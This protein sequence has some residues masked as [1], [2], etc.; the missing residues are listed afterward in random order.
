MP[1]KT[2]YILPISLVAGRRS[3][4][5]ATEWVLVRVARHEKYF[6]AGIHADCDPNQFTRPE[7]RCHHVTKA[8]RGLDWPK[9]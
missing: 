8:E 4:L 2:W 1:I 5:L 7:P 3:F 6:Q 9:S